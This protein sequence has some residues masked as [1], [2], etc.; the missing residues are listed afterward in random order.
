MSI[1]P[2]FFFKKKFPSKLN[3]DLRQRITFVAGLT[4]LIVFTLAVICFKPVLKSSLPLEYNSIVKKYA[5]EYSVDEALIYA[6]I[7][8]ESDF[9]PKAVSSAGAMGLMQIVPG[10]FK[11]LYEKNG[12]SYKN[13]ELFDPEINIKYGVFYLRF[14]L[15]MFSELET[16]IAAYNAGQGAVSDWL[17]NPEF[18]D[19]G[20]HLKYIPFSETRYYVK[21][22]TAALELYKKLYT[23]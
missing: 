7:K 14:L 20:I 1:T 2:V 6:V 18:S 5:R 13:E 11:W 23:F 9:N 3:Y 21:K 19:D 16:A 17:Q 4:L 15:D 10:T 12:E 8:T 22:V